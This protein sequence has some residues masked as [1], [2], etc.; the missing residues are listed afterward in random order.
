[1]SCIIAFFVDR[2]RINSLYLV[3]KSAISCFALA[4]MTPRFK[5]SGEKVLT[6]RSGRKRLR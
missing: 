4:A 3:T 6:E 1:M 2:V 5:V